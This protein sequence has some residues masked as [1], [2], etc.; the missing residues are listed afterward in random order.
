MKNSISPY[1]VTRSRR[2]RF[3]LLDF[4]F[5]S[6]KNN[7]IQIFRLLQNMHML[8]LIKLNALVHS[9][10]RAHSVWRHCFGSRKKSIKIIVKQKQMYENIDNYEE[11]ITE[12]QTKKQ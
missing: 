12:K 8:G 3:F 5:F 2:R 7:L 6:F 11:T 4:P 9:S 1:N 10:V